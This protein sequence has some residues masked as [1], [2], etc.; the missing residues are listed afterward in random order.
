MV[1]LWW[2][3]WSIVPELRSVAVVLTHNFFL[4][5]MD[6]GFAASSKWTRCIEARNL[7]LP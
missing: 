5:Y 4:T 3:F 7:L 1:V 6:H 2:I